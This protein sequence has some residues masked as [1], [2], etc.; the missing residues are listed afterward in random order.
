MNN[1]N[2]G[3]KRAKHTEYAR[4]TSLFR[5]LDNEI[6]KEKMKNKVYLKDEK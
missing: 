2:V 4:L 1:S 3:S 5:K 6:E